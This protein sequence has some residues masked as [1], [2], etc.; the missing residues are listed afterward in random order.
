MDTLCHRC[1]RPLSPRET[2]SVSVDHIHV[3]TAEELCAALAEC[4]ACEK[5]TFEADFCAQ[6]AKII[7]AVVTTSA[8]PGSTQAAVDAARAAP[9]KPR[10][11]DS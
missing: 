11:L 6:C 3:V 5:L 1:A 10:K 9:T 4:E 8:L 2:I 7:L